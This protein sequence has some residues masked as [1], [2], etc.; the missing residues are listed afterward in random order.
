MVFYPVLAYDSR[1]RDLSLLL[2]VLEWT[3]ETT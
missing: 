1:N 2:F 3:R